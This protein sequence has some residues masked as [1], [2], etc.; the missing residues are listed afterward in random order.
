M[1]MKCLWY[2]FV[3][4]KLFYYP[5]CSVVEVNIVTHSCL[6]WVLWV[7]VPC[8]QM[9]TVNFQ[10]CVIVVWMCEANKNCNVNGQCQTCCLP[11]CPVPSIRVLYVKNECTDGTSMYVRFMACVHKHLNHQMFCLNLLCYPINS[12]FCIHVLIRTLDFH[13]F[14]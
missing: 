11:G 3:L 5:C 1:S 4:L 7:C 6:E 9:T 8:V 10:L 14:L 2:T 12:Y 13:S